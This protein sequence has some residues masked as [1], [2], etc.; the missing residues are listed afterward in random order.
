MKVSSLIHQAVKYFAGAIRDIFTAGLIRNVSEGIDLRIIS[1]R[2]RREMAITGLSSIRHY[3]FEHSHGR[4][5]GY[6][7]VPNL[8]VVS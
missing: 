6:L 2:C 8:D 3:N 1:S 5:E 7:P 4:A